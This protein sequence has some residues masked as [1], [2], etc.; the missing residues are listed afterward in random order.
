MAS[1]T[2]GSAHDQYFDLYYSK[3]TFGEPR[4]KMY[5]VMR[6]EKHG[7]TDDPGWYF[8]TIT[9]DQSEIKKIVKQS[10]DY[11]STDGM[12]WVSNVND[13]MIAEI[14]PIDSRVFYI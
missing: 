10:I 8:K 4:Q 11:P 3:S 6:F 1:S 13:I 2:V 5:A 9:Q 14:I 7:Q 12:G